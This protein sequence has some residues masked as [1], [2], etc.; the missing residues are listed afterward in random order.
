[1]NLMNLMNFSMLV[2]G[3]EMFSHGKPSHKHQTWGRFSNP[4]R[5]AVGSWGW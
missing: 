3:S 4:S 1:M 2:N 5:K